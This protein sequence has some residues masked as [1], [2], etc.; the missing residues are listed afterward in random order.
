M[1]QA[2]GHLHP[3]K[4]LAWKSRDNILQSLGV[5]SY[6]ISRIGCLSE[7]ERWNWVLR[8]GQDFHWKVVRS[9]KSQKT[10][11][12]FLK[13]SFPLKLVIVPSGLPFSWINQFHQIE[14]LEKIKPWLRDWSNQTSLLEVICQA[15]QM[16][17][18]GVDPWVL[19]KGANKSLSF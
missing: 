19:Q 10:W 12:P 9:H 14:E 4:K 5:T 2:L 3:F 7:G 15:F 6:W 16:E 11:M 1:L 8:S 18:K 17:L 13:R